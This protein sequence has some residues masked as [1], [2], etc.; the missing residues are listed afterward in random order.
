MPCFLGCRDFVFLIALR[1]SIIFLLTNTPPLSWV[2]VHIYVSYYYLFDT[3]EMELNQF[4][5]RIKLPNFLKV[6]EAGG[7]MKSRKNFPQTHT[8][9][10]NPA[11]P[12]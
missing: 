7:F 12:L 4:L 1:I 10:W 11:K 3:M 9:W 6:F 2:W 8:K 5:T